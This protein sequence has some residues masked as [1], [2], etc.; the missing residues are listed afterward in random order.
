MKQ[1]T[2]IAVSTILNPKVLIADEPTTALDVTT[3]AQI[4]DLL[5]EIRQER[6]TAT[7]LVSHDLGVVAGAADRVAIM[8]AGKIVEIGTAEEI[9]YD[10]R[11]P[12]TRGL[13]RSLP[14]LNKG[15]EMLYTIPGMPPTLID[16]PQGDA[17]APRNEYAL[18]ID[19]QKEPP[20]FRITDTHYAATWL[21]DERA[22]QVM[23]PIGGNRR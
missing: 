6:Q 7:I 1:R 14:A 20:M 17:F 21:L 10:P 4:L 3:Q 9:Y 15:A 23:P 22:P 19:Y 8:Y 5:R 2:V 16:P 12:Y 13:M 18:A 11:H